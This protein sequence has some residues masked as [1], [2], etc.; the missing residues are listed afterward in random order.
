M[1]YSGV[2]FGLDVLVSI[3][4]G[5]GGAF[6]VWFKMKGKQDIQSV[7][8]TN[9]KSEFEDFKQDKK[10]AHKQIHQRIGDLKEKVEKNREN[11]DTAVSKMTTKM[12]EM[13][14]RIIK[15]I[16]EIKK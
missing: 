11:S 15:A 12:Q 3:I 9:L 10:E 13:E 6:G 7:E 4:F 8:M 5:A 1:D 2:T 14:L 16:H